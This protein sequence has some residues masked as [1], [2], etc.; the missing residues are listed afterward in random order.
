MGAHDHA[1]ATEPSTDAAAG[2]VSTAAA[3]VY[4]QFFVPALFR[5]FAEPMLDV[6]AAGDGDRLLDVGAGTGVVGRAALKRVGGRGSV[7]AV[8]PNEGML[9]VAERLAPAMDTRRGVAEQLPVDRAEMNCVTCQFALMFLSD[10][11]RAVEEM[12]RVL[13]PGGRVAVATWASV[14]DSPGYAAMVELLEEEIGDGA[15]DALRAPFCLGTPELIGDVLRQSFEDVTV[16][17]R[18]GQA[19]FTSLDDWL[20]TEIRGW[21]LAEHIDDD[22]YAR[23]RRAAATRLARF[24]TGDGAVRF[25]VPAL[26]AAASV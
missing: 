15:A 9:T 4:E 3:E 24:V 5:Q 1:M 18:E 7:V 2:Q 17:R 14:G 6:V 20:Y 19:R 25:A 11:R 22:Q 26:I 8:D 21:T 12:R 13:R 10:R 16:V 23:L